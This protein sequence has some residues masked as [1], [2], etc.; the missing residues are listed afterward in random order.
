MPATDPR[1]IIASTFIQSMIGGPSKAAQEAAKAKPKAAAPAPKET[2]KPKETP[3]PATDPEEKPEGEVAENPDPQETSPEIDVERIAQAAAEGAAR[4]M[5]EANRTTTPEPKPA[6][7]EDWP[8]Q[9]KSDAEVYETLARTNP[10]YKDI[11]RRIIESD[12]KEEQYIE[13][14]RQEHPGQRYNPSDPEHEP[15]F[16]S[17]TVTV[18]PAA[19][20]AAE[21]ASI[22]NRSK[23]ETLAEIQRQKQ[24]EA[25]QQARQALPEQANNVTSRI[26]GSIVT[27]HVPDF[28]LTAADSAAKLE[29][30]DPIL[31]AI[32]PDVVPRTK[33]MVSEVLAINSGLAE[34]N[35]QG[36][37]T[38]AEISRLVTELDGE[39]SARPMA[40]RT[41]VEAGVKRTYVSPGK[42]AQMS[43]DVAARHWTIQ[44]VDL[45]EKIAADTS[46][47]IETRRKR[48]EK[49]AGASKTTQARPAPGNRAPTPAPVNTRST[50]SSGGSGSGPAINDARGGAAPKENKFGPFLKAVIGR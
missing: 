14:W 3:A 32:L 38:H 20:K 4:G 42:Y 47:D 5:R 11:K 28:D 27:Q 33:A 45:V 9:Y 1:A 35:P 26:I 30:A 34:F 21:R 25:A 31:M 50:F 29:E 37:A 2:P 19:L 40:E 36:S 6:A 18:D 15:F 16:E 13:Q 43:A 8:E 23:R 17:I 12:K 24:E 41:R 49:I 22:A 44:A 10:R 7:A 48:F 39:I 46:A